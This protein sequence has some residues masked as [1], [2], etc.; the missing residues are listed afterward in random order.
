[1]RGTDST[2]P[3][4]KT[5]DDLASRAV[6]MGVPPLVVKEAVTAARAKFSAGSARRA[7]VRE[8]AYFWGV[9]RRCALRGAAPRVGETLVLA[10][11]AQELRNAGYG[12]EEVYSEV[13]RVYGGRMDAT[14]IGAYQPGS[15][16]IRAA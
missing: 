15:R 7:K 6:R 13:C 3:T 14:L 9:V 16:A 10:S 2:S 12:P 8:E 1:M 5:M 11:L 4:N